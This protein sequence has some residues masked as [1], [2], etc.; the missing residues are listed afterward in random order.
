MKALCSK[1]KAPKRGPDRYC[2]AC[3][4]AY[5]A[6]RSSPEAAKVRADKYYWT[7]TVPK[8][9]ARLEARYPLAKGKL[10]VYHPVNHD[11]VDAEGFEGMIFHRTS[12]VM[13]EE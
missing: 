6:K 13:P 8:L 11:T 2:A 5:N 9:R 1:C 4:K 10:G 12:D 7:V 3:R